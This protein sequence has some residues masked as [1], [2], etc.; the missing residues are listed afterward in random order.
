MITMPSVTGSPTRQYTPPT[1]N[2]ESGC[3]SFFNHAITSTPRTSKQ[4]SSSTSLHLQDHGTHHHQQQSMSP[5]SSSSDDSPTTSADN[6][7]FLQDDSEMHDYD[8]QLGM[9]V[10]ESSPEAIFFNGAHPSS[11]FTSAQGS[12]GF[13]PFAAGLTGLKL[14]HS[15]PEFNADGD[16]PGI[17]S[18]MRGLRINSSFPSPVQGTVR[19]EDVM[20]PVEDGMASMIPM[21]NGSIFEKRVDVQ[22]IANGL[23]QSYH[24]S[25]WCSDL[26][27]PISYHYLGFR[28]RVPKVVWRHKLN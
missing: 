23:F 17:G 26:V 15:S 28:L 22:P 25:F 13:S 24:P 1:S 9:K 2:D 10:E 6:N 5:P 11:R 3:I 14:S 7:T 4:S 21:T 18:E 8:Y 20:L 16:S 19:L 12:S 27:F